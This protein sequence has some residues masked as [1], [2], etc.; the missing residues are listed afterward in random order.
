MM[1]F[2]SINSYHVLTAINSGG[3][4]S[5]AFGALSIINPILFHKTK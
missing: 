1:A 4:L 3:D 2:Y 5:I